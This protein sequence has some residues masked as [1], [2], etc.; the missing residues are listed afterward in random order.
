[1]RVVSVNVSAA[2]AVPWRGRSVPTGIFKKPVAGRVRVGTRGLF[3]DVQADPAVHGGFKKAVYVY[4]SEHY[5]FWR[6]EYPSMELGWGMFG[7]NLTSEGLLETEVR[8]G[9]AL[10]I[11]S[12][13]AVV[14]QPRFPCFKLG[15]KFG[16]KDII[17]RFKRSERSGF[18]LAVSAPGD[19]AA[20]DPIE[21]LREA[22]GQPTVA[23]VVRARGGEV[24][25]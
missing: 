22:R 4:P 9:D 5:P 6:S 8:V 18:Y 25:V 12:A 7:E 14:T 16:R 15:I 24:E 10:R 3:G 1:V 2:R 11:G 13:E 20:G 21:V 23:E 19:V 17:E